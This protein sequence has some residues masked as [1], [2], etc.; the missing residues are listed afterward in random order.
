MPQIY[1]AFASQVKINQNTVEGLRSIEYD[2]VKNRRDI[3]AIGTDERIGVYFGLKCIIGKLRVASANV[4]LDDLL[5]NN[6]EFAISVLLKHGETE[7]KL[8]FFSCF[9]DDK[10]FA[11]GAAQHGETVYAFSATG[12]NEE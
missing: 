8:T 2:V 6:A 5:A 9:L 3:G 11:M 10:T 12:M 7:R 4:T 1:T